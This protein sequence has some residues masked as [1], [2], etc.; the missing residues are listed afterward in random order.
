SEEISVQTPPLSL[1]LCDPEKVIHPI[2]TAGCTFEEVSDPAV[3]C[4]Y[5]QA[6]YDDFQWE[7]VRI[8]PGTRAPADLPHGELLAISNKPGVVVYICNP[9]NKGDMDRRIKI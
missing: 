6:Q 9:S 2:L 1:E 3:P 4:E 5:N 8:H 7:Q